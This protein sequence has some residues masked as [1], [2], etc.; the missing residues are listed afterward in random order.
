MPKLRR[1]GTNS[2][3]SSLTLCDNA[4]PSRSAK[5]PTEL[6][7][8]ATMPN[9]TTT[10]IETKGYGIATLAC[11]VPVP[12]SPHGATLAE[13]R[14]SGVGHAPPG[15]QRRLF[16]AE[17]RRMIKMGMERRRRRFV[18]FTNASAPLCESDPSEPPFS[19]GPGFCTVDGP[20]E[21]LGGRQGRDITRRAHDGGKRKI[22][23]HLFPSLKKET[24]AT[25]PVSSTS[26]SSSASS[27]APSSLY[28]RLPRRL[29]PHYEA[30]LSR[31]SFYEFR[32]SEGGGCFGKLQV[33]GR[34][35]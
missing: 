19:F 35:K 6:S 34:H 1:R 25:P 4:E 12:W 30:C 20:C 13:M 16:D 5:M 3:T 18:R 17:A 11:V 23:K 24:D 22:R 21:Q 33:R 31:R 9:L 7:C 14:S 29:V 2:H 28:T 32:S 15:L 8:S 27:F 26:S 10:K